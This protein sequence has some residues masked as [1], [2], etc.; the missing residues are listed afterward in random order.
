MAGSK[1]KHEHTDEVQHDGGNIHHVVG[2][3]APAGKKTVE[4]SKNFLSPEVH[5]AFAGVAMRKLNHGDA[6]RP[7]KKRERDDPQPNR[8]AT[9]GGDGRNDVQI[10]N[11]NDKKQ[12]E[13]PAAQHAA[14]VRRFLCHGC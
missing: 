2:P 7:E 6:L 4:V 12:N 3:V 1:D 5:A 14:Q 8:Y 11:G 10:E 13:V 9:I